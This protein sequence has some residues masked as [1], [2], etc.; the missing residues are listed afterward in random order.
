MGIIAFLPLLERSL[1]RRYN[2]EGEIMT[3]IYIFYKDNEPAR[4]VF[5]DV[6]LEIAKEFCNDSRIKGE[7]W[8]CGFSNVDLGYEPLTDSN[9][10]IRFA[11]VLDELERR[12]I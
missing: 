1:Q 2:I 10:K 11:K 4:T 12:K 3:S 8:Y 6:P 5:E 7:G 9:L